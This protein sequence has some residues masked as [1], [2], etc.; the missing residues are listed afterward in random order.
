MNVTFPF[1]WSLRYVLGEGWPSPFSLHFDWMQPQRLFS[2]MKSGLPHTLNDQKLLLQNN[3]PGSIHE[4]VH[5]HIEKDD[6]H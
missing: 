3:K 2:C 6:I 1:G 5:P 4:K